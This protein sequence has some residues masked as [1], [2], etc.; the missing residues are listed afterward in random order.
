VERGHT[1][2]E[3]LTVNSSHGQFVTRS[4]R[5]KVTVGS[6]HSQLVTKYRTKLTKNVGCN[7]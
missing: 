3:T 2:R 6:S 4:A 7:I 1:A 5:H